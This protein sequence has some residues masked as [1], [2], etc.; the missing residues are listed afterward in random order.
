MLGS[1]VKNLLGSHTAPAERAP[2]SGTPLR[3]HIGGKEPH[4]DWKIVNVTPGEHTDYV[5]S[6]TDLSP[7]ASGSVAEIYAS[8]VLEH[9]G[10]RHELPLALRE[11]ERVLVAGGTLRM[12]VPDLTV[13]CAIF[14][15][16]ALTTKERAMVMQF[17]FGGQMDAAD[18]HRVGLYEELATTLLQQAGF[19]GIERVDTF[20]VFNDASSQKFRGRLISL[21]LAARK[22]GQES[23][24]APAATG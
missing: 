2:P 6:C 8:H 9:L 20:G 23:G 22:A 7:F 3:L 24:G 12:S 18:F 4:P 1:L 10:Y 15:D 21:N 17:M 5:R 19:T 16:P 11:F 13:L 14:G